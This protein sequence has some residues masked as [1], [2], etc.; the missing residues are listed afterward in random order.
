MRGTS[1]ASESA[2]ATNSA[3]YCASRR[4]S[5]NDIPVSASQRKITCPTRQRPLTGLKTQTT[6]IH[7]PR[8]DSLNSGAC[9][10][11][12]SPPKRPP[13]LSTMPGRDTPR[14][15]TSLRRS[16]FVAALLA[17][18]ILWLSLRA[19]RSN[20]GGSALR[21]VRPD[22]GLDLWVGLVVPAAA[23]EDAVM[24][25][26]ELQVVAVFIGREIAA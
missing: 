14:S 21:S 5:L 8:I 9:P 1:P 12:T 6:P 10:R 15:A 16:C 7:R 17:M 23:V 4:W 24:A 2:G 20:L 13:P 26:I 3:S 22:E 11:S 25:D 18:T 19:K